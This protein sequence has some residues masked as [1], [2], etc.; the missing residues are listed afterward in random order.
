MRIG[1]VGSGNVA[2]H[3]A[4]ALENAGNSVVA[5]YSRSDKNAKALTKRLYNA[6]VISNLDF[7]S[8]EIDL[9]IISIS[10]DALELVAKELIIPENVI[11]VHTSGSKPLSVLAYL[12][13]DQLGVFY[14]LQTFSKEKKIDFNEVPFLIESEEKEVNK[15][16]EKLGKSISKIVKMVHSD[17]RKS[18]HVA[19]VFACNFTNHMLRISN[20][21]LKEHD[22]NFELLKPLLVETMNKALAIGPESA[23][24]GPARRHDFDLLEKHMQF[25]EEDSDRA[26]IYKLVSQHIINTYSS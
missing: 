2:W 14:P 17:D 19:A 18:I 12:P 4:P 23:Q 21:L 13:T 8:F 20:D 7:S 1:F 3:L 15:K 26:E 24:T 6:A 5:V 10:D 22:L 16:L 9:I 11:I 25:L